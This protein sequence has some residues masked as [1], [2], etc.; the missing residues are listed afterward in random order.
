MHYDSQSQ[1]DSIEG[2][3]YLRPLPSLPCPCNLGVRLVNGT[4]WTEM[5]ACVSGVLE[6]YTGHH[7][8]ARFD[9]SS[10]VV[11]FRPS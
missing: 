11:R 1:R 2:S 9:L 10:G 8:P 6:S 7:I 4:Q 3:E 5:Y